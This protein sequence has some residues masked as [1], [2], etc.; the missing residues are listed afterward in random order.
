MSNSAMNNIRASIQYLV[1]LCITHLP[2]FATAQSV[3]DTTTTA[4][5]EAS[6]ELLYTES[7]NNSKIL[8]VT[9]KAK[10]G[11]DYVGVEGAVVGF[12]MTEAIPENSL[13]NSTTNDKGVA[14]FVVPLEKLGA[15]RANYT[16]V[17]SI[18]NNTTVE[19]QQEE[20]TVSESNLN[21][22]LEEVDSV[23]Q[24]VITLQTTDA[25]GNT[26]PAA[27]VEVRLFVQRMFGL[28]PLSSDPQLTDEQGEITLEFPAAIPGDT[29]G[30]LVV[31][32]KVDEHE[33]FGNLDFRKK[34]RWGVPLVID[35]NKNIRELWSS[36]ENAPYYLIIIVNS[37]LI[38]I[39]GVI[40]YIVFQV[41]RIRK[42]GR[43][44][45]A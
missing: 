25:A 29:A 44:K 15:L 8:T 43:Q 1:L 37:M 32:A 30:N 22:S 31:V 33:L 14:V 2:G 3:N 11:E 20:I 27:D 35:H 39:W 45:V 36:R 17:A 40:A 41:F 13:G 10:V 28:L 16:F 38:G 18:E 19:D 4:K 6:I 23:R 34:I 24:V 26:I 42:L 12:F 7:N 21:M 5:S 9:V